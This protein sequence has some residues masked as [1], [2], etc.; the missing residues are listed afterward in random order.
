MIDV[1]TKAYVLKNF[2]LDA[3]DFIRDRVSDLEWDREA[4]FRRVGLTSYRPGRA[5][6]GSISLLVLGAAVGGILGVAF[7]PR[8]GAET[9]V[10]VKD[11]ARKILEGA[12]R[13]PPG[14]IRPSTVAGY[15]QPRG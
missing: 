9:R 5:A 11:R 12:E 2:A 7:A 3:V 13:I 8:P 6:F 1:I 14:G 4:M 15:D 10:R